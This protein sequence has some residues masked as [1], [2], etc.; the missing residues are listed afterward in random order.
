METAY[1]LVTSEQFPSQQSKTVIKSVTKQSAFTCK[2]VWTHPSRSGLQFQ[3]CSEQTQ[4]KL[5]SNMF[6]PSSQE[7]MTI[8]Q[9]SRCFDPLIQFLNITNFAVTIPNLIYNPVKGSFNKPPPKSLDPTIKPLALG[10][11]ALN[12]DMAL[13]SMMAKLPT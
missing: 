9:P 3:H 8:L 2:R 5:P 6:S 4:L 7:F 13:N 1:N 12:T 11:L 10:F